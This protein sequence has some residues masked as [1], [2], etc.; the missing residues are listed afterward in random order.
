MLVTAPQV[1]VEGQCAV[2]PHPYVQVFMT[3]P[4]VPQT[5]PSDAHALAAPDG[6]SAPKLSTASHV[7]VIS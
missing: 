1:R 3:P 4:T 7:A 6:Q 5:A 2:S